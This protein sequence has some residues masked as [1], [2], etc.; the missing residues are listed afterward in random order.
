[1]IASCPLSGYSQ[2]RQGCSGRRPPETGSPNPQ[3]A[4]PIGRA[5]QEKALSTRSFGSCPCSLASLAGNVVVGAVDACSDSTM[6]R[7]QSHTPLLRVGS[8]ACLRAAAPLPLS[9]DTA[10]S[11]GC[12]RSDVNSRS[13]R[14]PR[15]TSHRIK[16]VRPVSSRAIFRSSHS[17][18]G[19]SA[20]LI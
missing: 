15:S 13:L 20:P 8:C 11:R 17:V 7:Q 3:D 10:N 14:T 5:R 2:A 9:R 18:S 6:S 16:S 12:F 4:M 19:L 1:M